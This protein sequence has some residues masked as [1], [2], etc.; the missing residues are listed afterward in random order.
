VRVALNGETVLQQSYRPSGL[1]REG[2]AFGLERVRVPPGEHEIKVWLMDDGQEWRPVFDQV[3][4]V[5]EGR[6][7]TLFFDREQDV[8]VL[9]QGVR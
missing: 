5:G 7:Q 2:M 3:V 8:F 9:H 6:V 1:R 4:P